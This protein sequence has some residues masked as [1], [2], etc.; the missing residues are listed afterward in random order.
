MIY[1]LENAG[2]QEIEKE[3]PQLELIWL[4]ERNDEKAEEVINLSSKSEDIYAYVVFSSPLPK[5]I[6]KEEE[7]LFSKYTSSDGK[8]YY[9]C[10]FGNF[11]LEKIGKRESS[12]IPSLTKEYQSRIKSEKVEPLLITQEEVADVIKNGKVIF[13][14][15]AGISVAAGTPDLD[16][17]S[18]YLGIDRSKSID[19]FAKAVMYDPEQ[20]RNKLINIQEKFFEKP[21]VAHM[22]LKEIQDI[23]NARI[24]SENLDKLGEAAGQ[25]IIRR[26]YIDK[27]LTK[28]NLKEIECV[29]TVGLRGDD[30]GLLYRFKHV[31]PKGR[32]IAI[33]I[34]PPPYLAENDYYLEGDAQILV[35]NILKRVKELS[36]LSIKTEI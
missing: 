1:P 8:E 3:S 12:S 2:T 28:K 10:G 26:G 24:A 27:V 21:T 9:Y 13:Y 35:P 30:S 11:D 6:G 34:A 36:E 19:N 4:N 33:N 29:I 32:I 14:T 20:M 22:S 31:N 16:V 23:T 5:E 7:S 25:E 17:L 18:N 15:G